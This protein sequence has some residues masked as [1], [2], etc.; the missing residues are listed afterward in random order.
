MSEV[1]FQFLV[2][3]DSLIRCRR[4]QCRVMPPQYRINQEFLEKILPV[5]FGT[6][7][8]VRRKCCNRLVP[9]TVSNLLLIFWRHWRHVQLPCEVH[10]TEKGGM[11]QRRMISSRHDYN[12]HTTH[13]QSQHWKTWR[14]ELGID[15]PGE[16]LCGC[17]K[18]LGGTAD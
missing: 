16:I 11:K 13:K 5:S 10:S 1:V 4:S 17:W 6:S 8:F 3:I 2:Y 12:S 18:S 14:V 15:Y 9:D 7:Q